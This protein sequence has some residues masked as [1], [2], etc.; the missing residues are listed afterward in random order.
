[1]QRPRS[2]WRRYIV[3]CQIDAAPEILWSLDKDGDGEL[4][5][6]ELKVTSGQLYYFNSVSYSEERDQI[7]LS[8]PNF[9]ELWVIDHSGTTEET[10]GAKGDLIFRY[11]NSET[12]SDDSN[13]TFQHKDKKLYWHDVQWLDDT[14]NKPVPH[15]G[16][17]SRD[18]LWGFA[19]RDGLPN[20]GETHM[21]FGTAYTKVLELTLPTKANGT[22]DWNGEVEMTCSYKAD[23][24][25]EMFAPFMSGCNHTL[26]GDT[27]ISLGHNKRFMR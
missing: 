4:N 12:Y 21:G 11:G 16:E 14:A 22:Y 5:E 9:S 20:P 27:I 8:S 23:P 17:Y 18:Q 19:W 25:Q 3:P 1:M 15:T 10:R 13:P 7:T 26:S 6:T 24:P 2:G